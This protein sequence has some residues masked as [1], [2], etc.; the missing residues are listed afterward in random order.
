MTDTKKLRSDIRSIMR[1][2]RANTP[3]AASPT[4]RK[5]ADL[6]K[7]FD[8]LNGDKVRAASITLFPSGCQYAAQGGCTMC[9]EWSG[10]NL[11][12]L[13]S[14]EFHV[15][16]FAAAVAD[17]FSENDTQ[18]IRIYQEGSFLN[19]KEVDP[20]ARET[21]LKL[22][23]ALKGVQRLTIESLPEYLTHDMAAS[24]RACVR[25]EVQMVI[26]I[27][28]EAKN[29]FIRTVCVGKGSVLTS[30]QRAVEAAKANNLVTLA[31]V[32]IKPPFLSEKEAI[33]EAISA[34]KYAFEIG[35]DEVYIQ[36]GSIH[37]WS[38]AEMLSFE[39]L[40]NPPW[41]WSVIEI[42]K[43][44][45]HL[46][47]VKIGGLEYYPNPAMTAQNY[48]DFD[49]QIACDCTSSIWHLIQEYNATGNAELFSS[50][51]CDCQDD[52]QTLLVPLDDTLPERVERV[53]S[54]VSVEKYIRKKQN[55]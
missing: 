36:A 26:G 32:L 50:I 16:Q 19:P 34:T 30:Y 3:K 22:G 51:T 49:N 42:V 12:E 48:S 47:I 52:W 5:P 25:S 23:S 1:Q 21:I 15:A 29:E 11:G 9:G 37:E 2:I 13:V 7:R 40:Y 10:S 46:G 28:L 53:L 39:G 4:W 45:T 6:S 44:T 24:I 18:W 17:V 27:G 38:L 14:A 55:D 20:G 8:F 35:F 31:Y 43:Q 54:S 33:D 41:L